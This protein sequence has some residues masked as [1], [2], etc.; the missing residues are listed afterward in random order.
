MPIERDDEAVERTMDD[1]AYLALVAVVCV[2]VSALA[3]AFA[4]GF[5]VGAGW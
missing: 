1:I 5:L 4:L 3:V 2:S